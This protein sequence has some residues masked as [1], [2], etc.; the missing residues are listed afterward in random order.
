SLRIAAQVAAPSFHFGFADNVQSEP[1]LGEQG[2]VGERTVITLREG[3]AVVSA[4]ASRQAGTHSML[5]AA[6]DGN[7]LG[8]SY[9]H[10]GTAVTWQATDTVPLQVLPRE[11]AQ[12]VFTL[13]SVDHHPLGRTDVLET[14]D[15]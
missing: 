5:L 10:A 7:E 14:G 1:L 6:L 13:R 11:P 15:A 4:T 9:D 8:F 12:L 3:R 2:Y